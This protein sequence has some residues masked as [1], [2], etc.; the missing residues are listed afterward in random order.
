MKVADAVVDVHQLALAAS[1]PR[2]RVEV[3]LE[4]VEDH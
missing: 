1:S 3:R 4:I 2:R